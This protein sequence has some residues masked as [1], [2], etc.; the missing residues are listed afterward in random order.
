LIESVAI[1]SICQQNSDSVLARRR[2][3]NANC[4]RYNARSDSSIA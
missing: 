1:L 4:R 3:V 2:L